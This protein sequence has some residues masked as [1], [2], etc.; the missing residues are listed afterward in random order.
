LRMQFSAQHRYYQ[1]QF[2]GAAFQ[3]ILLE[4]RPIGRLYVNRGAQ[5]ILVVDITLLPEFR[6]RGIGGAIMSDL[7][8]EAA[9]AAKP[10]RIH[11]EYFNPAIRFYE[12]L[13]FSKIRVDGAYFLLEC[14]PVAQ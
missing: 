13:G 7:L 3:I 10:V 11:V 5:E 4:E 2:A 9:H 1:E 6:N 14:L 8:A 12:R